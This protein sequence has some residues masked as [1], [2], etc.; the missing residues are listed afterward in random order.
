M[1]KKVKTIEIEVS[2]IILKAV[3]KKKIDVSNWKKIV[4]ECFVKK[5]NVAGLVMTAEEINC[6]EELKNC[7]KYFKEDANEI[8]RDCKL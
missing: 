4:I 1:N 6:E 3:K 8:K 7:N 2:E 5:N